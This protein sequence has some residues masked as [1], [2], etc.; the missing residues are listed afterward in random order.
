MAEL[1]ENEHGELLDFIT[2][3][4]I[5]RALPTGLKT[6]KAYIARCINYYKNIGRTQED[7]V[8]VIELSRKDKECKKGMGHKRQVM[9]LHVACIAH[10]KTYNIN[11]PLSDGLQSLMT[12]FNAAFCNEYIALFKAVRASNLEWIKDGKKKTIVVPS[13]VGEDE[14]IIQWASLPWAPIKE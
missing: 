12:S 7:F 10:K 8:Q 4:M 2:D 1:K 11:A 3:D 6:P 13:I 5:S 9:M 14:D